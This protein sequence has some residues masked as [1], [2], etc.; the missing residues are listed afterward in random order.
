[1]GKRGGIHDSRCNILGRTDAWR[2]SDLGENW[3]N[4]IGDKYV[5]DETGDEEM[6]LLDEVRPGS[7]S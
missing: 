4:L 7:E 1:M 2:N 3:L 5:F 6:G